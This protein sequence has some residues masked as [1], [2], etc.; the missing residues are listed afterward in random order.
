MNVTNNN[1]NSDQIKKTERTVFLELD[2]IIYRVIFPSHI[3]TTFLA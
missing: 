3:H 2:G 1:D